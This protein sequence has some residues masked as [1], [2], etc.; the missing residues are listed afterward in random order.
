MAPRPARLMPRSTRVSPEYIEGPITTEPMP[1]PGQMH[2][3][4]IVE[5]ETFPAGD[6]ATCLGVSCGS[7]GQCPDCCGNWNSCGPVPVWCLL[8]RPRLDNL[9]LH[10]GPERIEAG[11]WD[12][13]EARRDYF[14]AANARGERFWIYREHR[15][16]ASW[17]LHGVFA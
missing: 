14:V 5:R 15:D 16:P 1:V 11:W 2:E 7:C 6:C 8:P 13:E 3:E 10:A 17:Y 9:E 12:G 4:M